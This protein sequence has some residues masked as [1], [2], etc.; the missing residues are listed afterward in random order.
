MAHHNTDAWGDTAPEDRWLAS[1]YW[2]LSSAW[3]CTHILDHYFYTGDE[4]FLKEKIETLNEGIVFFLDTLQPYER[5]G[6]EYLVTSPSLSPENNYIGDDGKPHPL[7]IGPTCDFQILRHL[8]GDYLR[9]LK[10]IG[11]ES[12]DQTF[13]KRIKDTMAKFPPYQI[14]E[15]YPGVLQEWI[16][17]YKEAEPGHR[18]ISHL[19]ALHPGSLVP[20]PDAPGHDDV[21]WKA[22]RRTLEYRLKNGG[23][24]TGWSR[25]WTINWFARLLDGEQVAKNIQ[26]FYNVSVYNNLFDS[27]PPFQIDGNF[28]FTAGV[29]EALLQSHFITE[30]DAREVWL[31]PALPDGWASGK[32]TGLVARGGFVVDMEWSSG[33]VSKVKVKSKLG[34]DLVLKFGTSNE[35]P[36]VQGSDTAQTVQSSKNSKFEFSTQKNE[37]LELKLVW[38]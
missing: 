9:A 18:H 34:G 16:E 12:V 25:A 3:L 38:D 7:T 5:D 29:A 17:D 13:L 23:A 2:P 19:Y 33:L 1:T 28:G 11:D 31:L 14:S 32:V 20:P 4:D 24:G 26:G 36:R 6:E 15:R 21:L 35:T 8:F 30:D 10:M 37:E 22:A 27:H